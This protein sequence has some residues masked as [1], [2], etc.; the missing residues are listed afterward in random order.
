MILYFLRHGLAGL[1]SEWEGDD[2]GRPL[3]EEGITRTAKTGKLLAEMGLN[4]DRIITSPL[5]RAKQTAKIVAGKMNLEDRLIEDEHLVPGFDHNKL[6]EILSDYQ[7]DE[8]ILF[9][10]HEP[11]F[12]LT[13]SSLIRGGEIVCKKGGLARVDILDRKSLTGQ[14]I[15]LIPPKFLAG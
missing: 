11:D 4:I 2:W 15:W 1:R 5:V 7:E 13:F 14:L 8:C 12:S 6:S 9:V 3:T 10:G